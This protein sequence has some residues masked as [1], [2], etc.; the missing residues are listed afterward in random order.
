M[1][2]GRVLEIGARPRA[3]TLLSLPALAGAR[4]RLGL[5]LDGPHDW[6][7]NAHSG[8]QCQPDGGICR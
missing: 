5:D 7:G 1:I 8:R 6:A 3:D 2:G 4:E